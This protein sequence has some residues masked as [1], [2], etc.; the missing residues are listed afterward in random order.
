M[1]YASFWNRILAGLIDGA[2]LLP[3]E[4]LRIK[5]IPHT[6]K[7]SLVANILIGVYYVFFWMRYAA[8]PGMM[9]L[10]IRIIR[11][12]NL[13]LTIVRAILRFIGLQISCITIIGGLWMLWDKNKQMWHDKLAG[14]YVAK[15]GTGTV[16]I[17]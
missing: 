16:D 10:Q 3:F 6:W 1:Q 11:K 4:I 2:I 5:Y 9:V 17:L 7:A 14:T 15:K 13:P 8:T 12:E